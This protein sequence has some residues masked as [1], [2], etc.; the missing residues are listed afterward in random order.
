MDDSQFEEFLKDQGLIQS[1]GKPVQTQCIFCSIISGQ[2]AS[3]K[4][5][6]NE[7]AIAVLEINPISFGHTIIIPREHLS[8]KEQLSKEIFSFAEEISKKIKE[9]LN[10]KNVLIEPSNILGH[11]IINI[12]P[13]YENENLNSSRKKTQPE[14]LEEVIKEPEEINE[15]NTWLPKRIP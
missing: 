11:E 5:Q 10:P 15:K 7:N 12:I 1:E 3:H 4:I 9:Q 2:V 6:E 14:Q 8:S 13:V